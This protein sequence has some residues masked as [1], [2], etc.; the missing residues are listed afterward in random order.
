MGIHSSLRVTRFGYF[1]LDSHHH[2]GVSN[3][4][5]VNSLGLKHSSCNRPEGA[6]QNLKR[7]PKH[8]VTFP[9][10]PDVRRLFLEL[11]YQ[12]Y[13]DKP[14][15]EGFPQPGLHDSDPTNADVQLIQRLEQS[16]EK[17]ASFLQ[18]HAEPWLFRFHAVHSGV[19]LTSYRHNGKLHTYKITGNAVTLDDS[20]NRTI[21]VDGQSSV[22]KNVSVIFN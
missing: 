7:T 6:P 3:L 1:N 20:T 5:E 16:L 17:L 8:V 18:L 11:D 13:P 4:A 22:G 21:S 10:M 15:A 19:S 9:L 2:E 14:V 12:G